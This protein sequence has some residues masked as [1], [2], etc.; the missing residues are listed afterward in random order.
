M[1]K[2]VLLIIA[3]WSV[4]ACLAQER[5]RAGVVRGTVITTGEDRVVLERVEAGGQFTLE[6]GFVKTDGGKWVR[7]P[8]QLAL[9]RTLKPGDKLV[10]RWQL[11]EGNHF[12]IQEMA[13]L[14]ADGKPL[15]REGAGREGAG[16]RAGG[17][18]RGGPHA[19]TGAPREH[20]E[21][22][23]QPREHAEGGDQPREHAEG[24]DQ[25]REHAEGGDRPAA[26]ERREGGDAA[27]QIQAL[28]TE[29]ATLK[30]EIAQLR[31]LLLQV[32]EADK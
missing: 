22:G 20:A 4:T 23:D 10:A 21:G 17:G 14:G 13:K 32:L 7:N 12:M 18:D 29:I 25:P 1:R 15:P 8:H 24:G 2:T 28:R 6:A 11:G 30:Q 3:V 16:E 9:I 31:K 26:A 5:E 19:E 27:H